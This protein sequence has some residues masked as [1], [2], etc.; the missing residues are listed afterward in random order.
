MV[1]REC[2]YIEAVKNTEGFDLRDLD[3]FDLAAMFKLKL[4][5]VLSDASCESCIGVDKIR[6]S[7]FRYDCEKEVDSKYYVTMFMPF[8][9]DNSIYNKLSIKLTPFTAKLVDERNRYWANRVIDDELTKFWRK[10]MLKCYG[11][12]WENA[13]LRC[14]YEEKQCQRAF[15]RLETGKSEFALS[16]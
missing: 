10:Y 2:D 6:F 14:K 4:S 9:Y 8:E 7:G 12:K 16:I 1:K 11:D 15:G 3:Y 13:F 5:G